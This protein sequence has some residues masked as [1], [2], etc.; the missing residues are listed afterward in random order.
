MCACV[1]VHQH[2]YDCGYVCTCLVFNLCCYFQDGNT[3][4]HDA[5]ENGHVSV[6]ESL[7]TSGHSLEPKNNVSHI[8]R[9]AFLFVYE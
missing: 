1:R 4:L 6:V 8:I 5:A 2:V 9:D 7:L 3:P